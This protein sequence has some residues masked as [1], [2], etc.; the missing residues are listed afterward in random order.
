[1]EDKI[2]NG[3]YKCISCDNTLTQLEDDCLCPICY[4][5]NIEEVL[6]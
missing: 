2:P 3:L 1:M 6:N 4:S 5:G